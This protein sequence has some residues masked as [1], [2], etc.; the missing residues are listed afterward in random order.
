MEMKEIE[1]KSVEDLQVELR[2]L[3]QELRALTFQ[4]SSNQLANV[5]KVRKVKKDIAR[6]KTVLRKRELAA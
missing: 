6:I 3:E 2:D 1:K 4:L 5:R